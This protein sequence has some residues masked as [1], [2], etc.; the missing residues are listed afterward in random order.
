L[1]NI[2]AMILAVPVVIILYLCSVAYPYASAIFRIPPQVTSLSGLFSQRHVGTV[3]KVTYYDTEQFD[4]YS[5]IHDFCKL[6]PNLVNS[7]GDVMVA[8]ACI[9]RNMVLF[10]GMTETLTLLIKQHPEVIKR[11]VLEA[12]LRENEIMIS[13]GIPEPFT[14]H[15]D[16][17]FKFFNPRIDVYALPITVTVKAK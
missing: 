6:R 17:L 4:F 13:Y 9:T 11:V 2:A 8:R 1:T 10:D 3:A 15:V 16:Y 5:K 14:A 12:D 7:T